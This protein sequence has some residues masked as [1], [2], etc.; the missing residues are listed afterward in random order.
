[1]RIRRLLKLI[2]GL[3]AAT[4]LGVVLLIFVCPMTSVM[5]M[6]HGAVNDQTLCAD[7]GLVNNLGAMS[8]CVD[9]HLANARQFI[10][11]L[12]SP[13]LF[14]VGLAVLAVILTGIFGVFKNLMAKVVFGAAV[15]LRQRF[16]LFYHSIRQQ[17]QKTLLAYLADLENSGNVSLV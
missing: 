14:L 9:M 8:A 7:A 1:M 4:M 17:F 6:T 10:S 2:S 3:T 13:T 5:P 12:F 15:R 11:N 16:R